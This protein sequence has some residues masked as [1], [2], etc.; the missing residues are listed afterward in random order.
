MTRRPLVREM[1]KQAI[2]ELGGRA[3][4]IE[5]CD[6][7]LARYPDVNPGTIN[8]QINWYTVNL[9][10]RTHAPENQRP[11]TA[12]DP[13]YDLLYRVERG[14]VERYDPSR[15]GVWAIV[16]GADGRLLAT[17]IDDAQE[18]ESD[19][20]TLEGKLD[21]SAAAEPSSGFSMKQHLR[22]FL[23]TNIGSLDLPGAPLTLYT[24][25]TGQSGVEYRTAIGPIDILA[26]D[27]SGDFVVVELKLGRGAD[28]AVGQ[29]ARYMGWV[30]E[31]LAGD[32]AVRGII[33]ARTVDDRLRYAASVLPTVA[34]FKYDVSFTL[35]PADGVN[36]G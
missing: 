34:L 26:V 24:D 27:A 22:E 12:T 32:R 31:H 36:Q 21:Q 33:V 3:R 28:T 2:D 10:S 8:S 16:K 6:A 7:I 11:R 13:R 35:Q 17:Q 5:I 20:T 29:L 14:V 1:I 19:A 9:Q 25:D 4:N 30:H 15:H 23:V 18:N